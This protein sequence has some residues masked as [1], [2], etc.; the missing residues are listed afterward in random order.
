[1]IQRGINRRELLK[2]TAAGTGAIVMGR[3][4]AGYALADVPK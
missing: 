3:Y 4:F 2:L 1:M